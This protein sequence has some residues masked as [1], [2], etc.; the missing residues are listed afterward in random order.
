MFAPADGV[1]PRLDDET[2]ILDASVLLAACGIVLQLLVSPAVATDVVT[3][4]RGVRQARDIKL[5]RPH[6]PPRVGR[7]G[8]SCIRRSPR[9]LCVGTTA[10]RADDDAQQSEPH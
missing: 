10:G 8:T 7:L 1:A 5:V 4:F 2:A 6:Q 3:P 9:A